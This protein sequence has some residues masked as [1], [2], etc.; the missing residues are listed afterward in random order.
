MNK[1]I[2]IVGMGMDGVLT[3]TH[4][5]K[6]ALDNAELLIGAER[7][8]KPFKK[9]GKSFFCEYKSEAIAEY[10]NKS[11]E[12]HIAV[13]M[14]GDCGFYSGA[15][16]LKSLLDG[17]D[18]EIICGISSPVYF[19]S[20][21]D[22]PWNDMLFVSLHGRTAN[23]ARLTSAHKKVFY[24]LGGN[25]T[26]ANICRQLCNYGLES[27][28]VYI[29]ENLSMENE[30]I[31]SGRAEELT[32]LETDNLCVVVTVNPDSEKRLK[33]GI[34]DNEFIREKIPMT[35]SEVRSVVISKL[36]INNND[37]CWDI[38]CGSG[39]VSVEMA[40]QCEN[41]TVYAVDKNSA[42]AELTQKNS[43]KFSCDNI[44]ILTGRAEDIVCS[45]PIPE[46][47]FVGGSG[48]AIE[49]IIDTAYNKNR[50]VKI[51]INAVSLETLEKAVNI[52]NKIGLEPEITQIAVTRTQKKRSYTMLSAENPVFIIKRK[53]P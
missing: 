9:T 10:I 16:S 12:R 33:T 14:S 47:V 50:N 3:L 51:V 25:I 30:R 35:K 13:L 34:D 37:I 26:A 19:C 29:G 22:V 8:L 49:K 53:F 7:M 42:A 18:T 39:S 24:L 36:E 38:G 31:I 6:T 5:A 15:Q 21:I 23:I 17:I 4:K 28:S 41:G 2:S 52:F 43:I 27:V 44:K 46:C 32:D 48:G 20:K 45:L 40:I 1:K 11:P